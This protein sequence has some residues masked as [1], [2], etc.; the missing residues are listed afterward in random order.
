MRLATRRHWQNYVAALRFAAVAVVL[1]PLPNKVETRG[2]VGA[3]S[4]RAVRLYRQV[5][6][7]SGP[8]PDTATRQRVYP[9][10][11]R[12]FLHGGTD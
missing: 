3:E 7:L 11:A 1:L 8:R 9:T 12:A 10:L 4:E 2:V 6:A 5:L